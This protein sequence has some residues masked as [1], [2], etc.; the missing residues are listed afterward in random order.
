[1]QNSGNSRGRKT[2]LWI[3]PSSLE[4]LRRRNKIPMEGVTETKFRAEIE[5]DHHFL[6]GVFLRVV[7]T[8]EFAGPRSNRVSNLHPQPKGGADPQSPVYLP[9]QR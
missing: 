8:G 2:K 9:C 1:L 6:S 5:R 3:L 7:L 4:V